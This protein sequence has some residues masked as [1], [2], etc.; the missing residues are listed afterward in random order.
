MKYLFSIVSLIL[1]LTLSSCSHF[2]EK[3]LQT[4]KNFN[5]IIPVNVWEASLRYEKPHGIAHTDEYLIPDAKGLILL[6]PQWHKHPDSAVLD[7]I[8]D[9][10]TQIQEEIYIALKS[11]VVDFGINYIGIEG[12]S[13]KNIDLNSKFFMFI[14]ELEKEKNEMTDIHE[15][16]LQDEANP[17]IL[18]IMQKGVT[19][20]SAYTERLIKLQSASLRIKKEFGSDVILSGIENTKEKEDAL[21]IFHIRNHAYAHLLYLLYLDH[22]K[23]NNVKLSNLVNS[24]NILNYSFLK[25]KL[26]MMSKKP[27]GLDH[28][29]NMYLSLNALRARNEKGYDPLKHFYEILR[30]TALYNSFIEKINF[31]ITDRESDENIFADVKDL[32]KMKNIFKKVQSEFQKHVKNNRE[33]VVVKN[34]SEEMTEKNLTCGII[35]FGAAHKNLISQF[36]QAGYSVLVLK[37]PTVMQESLK[38]KDEVML[39][40]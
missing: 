33:I 6:I 15:T 20:C 40:Q 9:L 17:Y 2:P 3:Q 21:K 27:S 8:N 26:M 1:I 29:I 10:S 7:L 36:N 39:L 18:K 5:V 13:T 4:E 34:V 14:N 24:T 38:D 23:K 25:S 19:F 12:P 16:M 35:I 37:T 28:R 11:L 30:F 22:A 32:E 31:D